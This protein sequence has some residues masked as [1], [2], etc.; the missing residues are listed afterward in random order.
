LTKSD[1]FFLNSLKPKLLRKTIKLLYLN[2]SKKTMVKSKKNIADKLTEVLKRTGYVSNIEFFEGEFHED[3]RKD[4]P[5]YIK[6]KIYTRD[7]TQDTKLHELE[8]HI[9]YGF[10]DS[11]YPD[12]DIN[13]C[14]EDI[15]ES[16]ERHTINVR[17]NKNNGREKKGKRVMKMAIHLRKLIEEYHFKNKQKN[18]KI[19]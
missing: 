1:Y 12:C 4:V 10:Y 2:I 8:K 19:L 14:I 16:L 11:H 5:P 6:Y 7:K 18:Y 13:T 9:R 15:G 17:F 3:S